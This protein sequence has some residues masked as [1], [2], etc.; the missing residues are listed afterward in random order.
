MICPLR[1]MLDLSFYFSDIIAMFS[2]NFPPL[3]LFLFADKS[4]APLLL[5]LLISLHDFDPYHSVYVSPNQFIISEGE[6]LNDSDCSDFRTNFHVF[7]KKTHNLVHKQKICLF[8]FCRHCSQ[9]D[10]CR[11]KTN[12]Y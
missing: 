2:R 6:A 12:N 7:F 8:R 9:L 11:K 4:S 10:F 5:P 1:D 3:P